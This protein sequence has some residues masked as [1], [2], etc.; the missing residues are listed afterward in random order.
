MLKASDF[1]AWTGT[2]AGMV[3]STRMVLRHRVRYFVLIATTVASLF[4]VQ[5]LFFPVGTV[6]FALEAVETDQAVPLADIASWAERA[7]SWVSIFDTDEPQVLTRISKASCWVTNAIAIKLFIEVDYVCLPWR[8]PPGAIVAGAI[9]SDITSLMPAS[10]HARLLSFATPPMARI[11]TNSLRFMVATVSMMVLAILIYTLLSHYLDDRLRYGLEVNALTGFPVLASIG[12]LPGG[13]LQFSNAALRL[14]ASSEHSEVFHRLRLM[15][16][17]PRKSLGTLTVCVT[18]CEP[19]EGKST[20]AASLALSCAQAGFRTIVVDADVSRPSQPRL[21]GQAPRA[22]WLDAVRKSLVREPHN[23]EIHDIHD[24]DIEAIATD[25]DRLDVVHCGL[26][27]HDRHYLVSCGFDRVLRRLER[28]ADVVILDSGPLS[29]TAESVV[30]CSAADVVA[31]VVCPGKTR[32]SEL[33]RM[34]EVLRQLGCESVAGV[35]NRVTPHSGAYDPKYYLAYG[36]GS[37]GEIE[38]ES[39]RAGDLAARPSTVMG[40]NASEDK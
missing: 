22:G 36:Y 21:F 8:R 39:V 33:L 3:V 9:Q 12:N 5:Q 13:L 16:M 37:Y 20:V 17:L 7:A 29:R 24:I 28:D 30:F 23:T 19:G 11:W 40:A 35:L 38:V 14:G 31:L 25:W 4:V 1:K 32:R 6:R 18:S 15:L 27:R 10:I 26:P 34:G 2:I